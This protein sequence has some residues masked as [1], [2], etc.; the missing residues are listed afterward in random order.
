MSSGKY[1]LAL[2]SASVFKVLQAKQINKQ[3]PQSKQMHSGSRCWRASTPQTAGGHSPAPAGH[4][5]GLPAGIRSKH[6][7]LAPG[8][9]DGPGRPPCE[10]PSHRPDPPTSGDTPKES[11]PL[12]RNQPEPPACSHGHQTRRPGSPDADGLCRMRLGDTGR[13]PPQGSGRRTRASPGR[14]PGW[15]PS[16]AGAEGGSVH[17]LCPR[18]QVGGYSGAAALANSLQRPQNAKNRMIT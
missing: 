8:P 14:C 16:C 18:G 3:K 7:E 17:A 11:R 12:E 9:R 6:P 5:P 2:K 15:C 13:Q 10:P 1:Q 4:S